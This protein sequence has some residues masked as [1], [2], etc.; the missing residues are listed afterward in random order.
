MPTEVHSSRWRARSTSRTMGLLRT[1]F[2]MAYSKASGISGQP[3]SGAQLRA[4]RPRVLRHFPGVRRQ[5]FAGEHADERFTALERAERV[6]H[7][8]VLERMKSDDD[9]PRAGAQP[10]GRRLDEPIEALELAVHPD[11]DRLKGSGRRVDAHEAAAGNGAADDGRQPGRRGD[12]RLVPR[13]DD[14]SGNAA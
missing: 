8:A 4:S 9:E 1:S 14:G 2:L 13:R 11:P 7:D 5:R 10:G 6:L 12:R 3:F